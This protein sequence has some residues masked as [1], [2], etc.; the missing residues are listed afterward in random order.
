MAIDPVSFEIIRHRLYRVVEEA[1]VS[2]TCQAA[3][4][5]TKATI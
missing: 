1:V 3:Q 5:P 4:P 2:R